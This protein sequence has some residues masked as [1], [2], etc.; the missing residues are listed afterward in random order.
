MRGNRLHRS[1]LVCGL[2]RRYEEVLELLRSISVETG[3]EMMLVACAPG[4][5][6]ANDQ[7]LRIHA[8]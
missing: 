7:P 4:L 5:S 2:A 3:D 6:I 1:S 8:T